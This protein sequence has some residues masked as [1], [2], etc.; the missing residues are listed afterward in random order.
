MAGSFSDAWENIVLDTIFG[1]HNTTNVSTGKLANLQARLYN[2]ALTDTGTALTNQCA[3]ATYHQVAITNSTTMWAQSTGGTKKL[4]KAV[5]FTT[6][7]G[8]DWGTLKGIA[9]CDTTSTG[10]GNIIVWTTLA[11]KVINTGDSVTLTTAFT[12]TL[13]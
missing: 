6:A 2:V 1:R 13:S 11:D 10:A 9:I 7:A 5:V 4:K 12:V 3:G 8:S